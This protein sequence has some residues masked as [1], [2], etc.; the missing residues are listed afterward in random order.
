MWKIGQ[1]MPKKYGLEGDL[2]QALYADV[3]EWLQALGGRAF[4]GGERPNLAD[5]AVFGVLR[6]VDKTPTFQDTVANTHVGGWYVR[7]SQAVGVSS[8]VS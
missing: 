1:G 2:R 3:N 7:M 4:M 5:L 6:A 8:R